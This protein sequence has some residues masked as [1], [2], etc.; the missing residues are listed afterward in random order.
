VKVNCRSSAPLLVIQ[1]GIFGKHTHRVL[2]DAARALPLSPRRLS[3][4]WPQKSA[5]APTAL[6]DGR[7][8]A[9]ARS[10]K[11]RRDDISPPPSQM[12]ASADAVGNVAATE[13][14]RLLKGLL[15]DRGVG[16]NVGACRC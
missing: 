1:L 11:S 5:S 7:A 8:I 12:P 14:L 2:S 3:D 6:A 10:A 15:V 16:V 9:M 13:V 4:G